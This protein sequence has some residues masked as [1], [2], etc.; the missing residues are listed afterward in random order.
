MSKSDY[1]VQVGSEL[2]KMAEFILQEAREKAREIMTRADEEAEKEKTA[3]I[4]S[5]KA[6]IEA[7]YAK[8][9][10]E[11]E[12]SREVA[13]SRARRK[14]RFAVGFEK[15]RIVNGVFDLAQSRLGELSADKDEYRK[16]L[17]N[18]ILQGLY[19][20]NKKCLV[21]VRPQDVEIAK[22]A[23]EAAA[24]EYKEKV[25]KDIDVSLDES[26]QL[27][28]DSAGGATIT[29]QDGKVWLVNTFERRLELQKEEAMPQVVETL[30]G[31]NPNRK[32]D[33]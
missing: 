4:R 29:C 22:G 33:S 30:F 19:R 27:P 7:E 1:E 31:K 3:I 13:K 11:L 26:T 6:A 8:K 14:A 32:F 24:K 21:Q 20:Y 28:K 9:Y 10:K 15:E 12:R 2:R 18:L 25:G 16:T 17:K 23:I 5:E